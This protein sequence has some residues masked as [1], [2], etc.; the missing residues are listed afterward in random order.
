MVSETKRIYEY[1][2]DMIINDMDP[3]I[4]GKLIFLYICEHAGLLKIKVKTLY[5][6]CIDKIK[7]EKSFNN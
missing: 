5:N 1:K 4:S 2:Y 3:D 7:F 6:I